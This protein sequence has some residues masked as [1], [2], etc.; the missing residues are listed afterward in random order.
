MADALGKMKEVQK[1][2][3]LN[4]ANKVDLAKLHPN[5][6]VSYY[7]CHWKSHLLFPSIVNFSKS[8][9]TYLHDQILSV[10][11]ECFTS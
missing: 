3:C 5:V 11:H 6:M 8:A 1:M 9:Y 10:E 2:R 7:S 4:K